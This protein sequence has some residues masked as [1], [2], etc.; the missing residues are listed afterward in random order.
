MR[1]ANY[2]CPG[3]FNEANRGPRLATTPT[4]QPRRSLSSPSF[5]Y[6]GQSSSA[7]AE[8]HQLCALGAA[9]DL[10]LEHRADAARVELELQR[11]GLERA[12]LAGQEHFA[13]VARRHLGLLADAD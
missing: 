2:C 8:A 10:D 5:S 7:P 1:L 4:D 12:R 11:L 6:V 3:S 13:V 9:G